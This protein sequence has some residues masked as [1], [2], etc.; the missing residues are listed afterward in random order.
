MALGFHATEFRPA[1]MTAMVMKFPGAKFDQELW[2]Q[3]MVNI[4]AKL[5]ALDDMLA[6]SK[7]VA[8]DDISIADLQLYA[9]YRNV[10]YLANFKIDVSGYKNIKKWV[11]EC[12]KNESIAHIHGE[13]APWTTEVLPQIQSMLK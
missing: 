11:D 6:N 8:G 9:E 2:D 4:V 1:F 5:K 7:F 10:D 3:R 13:K 12:N